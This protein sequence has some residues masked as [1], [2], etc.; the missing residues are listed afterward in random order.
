[1]IDEVFVVGEAGLGLGLGRTSALDPKTAALLQV[2]ALVAGGSSAVGLEWSAGQ[3]LA[4]GAS[5]DEIA[6]VLLAIAPVAGL[7]RVAAAA[8]D[9]ATALGYDVAAALEEPDDP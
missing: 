5:E 2:A 8:P 4:A 9:L 7:G 1:M 3:A 6:D